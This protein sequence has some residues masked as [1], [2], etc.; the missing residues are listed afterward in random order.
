M[1]ARIDPF[2][3]VLLRER[4]DQLYLLPDEPVTMAMRL[5]LHHRRG[6]A[7]AGD[8]RVHA[9]SDRAARRRLRAFARGVRAR[10]HRSRAVRASAELH[11]D[12]TLNLGPSW[13]G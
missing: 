11:A 7:S 4:G 12:A 9:A 1:A 3:D 6:R 10:S 5:T 8:L 13:G 2:I